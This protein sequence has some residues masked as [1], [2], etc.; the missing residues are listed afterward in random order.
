MASSGTNFRVI[1]GPTGFDPQT[2]GT[3]VIAT[4]TAAAITGLVPLGT[5]DFYV[6]S[7]C[8]GGTGSALAGPRRFTTLCPPPTLTAPGTENF[9]GTAVNA[10]SC[11]WTVLNTNADTAQW[12]VLNIGPL[13]TSAPNG[14]RI[15]SETPKDD[16]F[17]SPAS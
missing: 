3:T 8:A 1:Y 2:S 14:L 4:G 16:W 12:R 7:N 11:G 15:D 17:V 10:L 5:Y 13:T 6:Q 9:D